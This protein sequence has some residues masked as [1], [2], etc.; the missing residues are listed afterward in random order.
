MMHKSTPNYFVW[1]AAIL[2]GI[3]CAWLALPA[4]TLS[5]DSFVRWVDSLSN[6]LVFILLATLPLFGFPVG[7]LYFLA[8]AKFGFAWGLA[9][10]SVSIAVNLLVT[11]W[12]SRRYLKGP[13]RRWFLSKQVGL[14]EVKDREYVALALLTPLVPGP[15][16]I[17][18]Y[19][20]G[21]SEIPFLPYFAIGLPVYVLRASATILFGGVAMDLN[22]TRGLWFALYAIV[23]GLVGWYVVRRWT[24]PGA[25]PQAVEALTRGSEQARA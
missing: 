11:R 15:F 25:Q 6:P 13:L 4:G 21:L 9:A 19:L 16:A 8:G 23:S 20:I 5:L 17:K 1:A 2:A 7:I 14:P 22:W 18:N 10:T 24:S 3:V 12:V